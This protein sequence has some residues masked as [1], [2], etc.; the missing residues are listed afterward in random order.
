MAKRV[1]NYQESA[2]KQELNDRVISFLSLIVFNRKR[3]LLHPRRFEIKSRYFRNF[4]LHHDLILIALESSYAFDKG[5][6]WTH[7]HTHTRKYAVSNQCRMEFH[8]N[9]FLFLRETPSIAERPHKRKNAQS[10][11]SIYREHATRTWTVCPNFPSAPLRQTFEYIACVSQI[12]YTFYIESRNQLHA[13]STV[14][15]SN[16]RPAGKLPQIGGSNTGY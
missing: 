10:G 16:D 14:E 7:T 3:T 4:S 9:A 5:R 11:K 1:S 15:I 13:L 6:V 12:R 2:N 8:S